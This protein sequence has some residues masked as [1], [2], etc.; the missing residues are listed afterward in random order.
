MGWEAVVSSAV[1]RRDGTVE[2]TGR[3]TVARLVRVVWAFALLQ[4]CAM[5]DHSEPPVAGPSAFV[6]DSATGGGR[7]GGTFFILAEVDGA[8]AKWDSLRASHKASYGQGANMRLVNYERQVPA[9]HR[10]LKLYAIHDYAA[11]IQSL[12]GSGTAGPVDGVVEVDLREG[13][14]YR[15]N[16]ALDRFHAEVWIEEEATGAVVG[17]KIVKQANDPEW[18]KISASASFTCCNLHYDDDWIGDS[19]WS[20]LPM[21]PAGSRIVV[22]D[23][24]SDRARVLIEGRKMRIGSDSSVGKQTID[25]FLAKVIVRDDPKAIVS[26]YAPPVQKAI[27]AGKIAIG[28]TKEQAILSLGY[29]RMD[30]T[31]SIDAPRWTYGTD[32][33]HP[34]ALVWSA[35]GRVQ[36]ID[37]A[38]DVASQVATKLSEP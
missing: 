2:R 11:P 26:G 30:A 20:S 1:P 24:G 12:L 10:R 25:E 13:E 15:V 34:F 35:D 27:R 17:D 9:G 22:K 33:D 28:M 23:T 4:G 38:P 36:Q 29:P 14:R 3:S 31:P 6:A 32:E 5:F 16:G 7:H 21:I 19:N 8:A 18:V 37:A